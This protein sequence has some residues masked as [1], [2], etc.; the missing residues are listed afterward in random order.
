MNRFIAKFH[1]RIGSAHLA[2]SISALVLAIAVPAHGQQRLNLPPAPQLQA[3]TVRPLAPAPPAPVGMNVAT[4]R[5]LAR[6]G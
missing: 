1:N 3:P 6:P 4:L 2:A 5:V